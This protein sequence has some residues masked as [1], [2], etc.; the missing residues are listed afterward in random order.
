[1]AEIAT[2]FG[3]GPDVV[4][5]APGRVTLIGE[6]TDYNGG[7]VLPMPIPQR[8]TVA[9]S[10]RN[11]DVARV[12]SDAAAG[13]ARE[14]LV[15]REAAAGDW[16]DYVQGCTRML[17]GHGAIGG[18]DATIT[19]TVPMGAG[20][21]SSAALEVALLRALRELFVVALD[22]VS[23]ALAAHRAEH[24]FVGARVGVMDQLA[25]SLGTD[26]HALFLD[27]RSLEH[28]SIPIPP[29]VVLRVLDSGIAHRHA[30]GDY[31]VRRAECEAACE[32]LGIR[33][34][35]DL[36][37][38]DL[39]R[40][41]TLPAVLQRRVHHVVTENARVLDAVAALRGG[42]ADRLGRLFVKSHASLRVDF[43]VSIPEVD[44]LVEIAVAQPEVLG[45]RMTGGG[46]GGAV[47]VVARADADAELARRICGLY[48]TRTGAAGRVLV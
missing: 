45:A 42:D 20:L 6:H 7:Y 1:M 25:S 9:A 27:A 43:E 35:R 10:R 29:T 5:S 15:G 11:D 4:A 3:G 44:A 21:A 22:D 16:L 41:T 12:S 8:T 33:Q 32:R 36:E 34:L 38:K 39:A 24:D 31:N 18:F 47:V 26:G 37:M 46:F 23:L 30:D 2:H 19:S 13:G 48:A 28:E 40:T 14:F 17:G